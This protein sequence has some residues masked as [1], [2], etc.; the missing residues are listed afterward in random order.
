[1][2]TK[3]GLDFGF[4]DSK[5]NNSLEV[6]NSISEFDGGDYWIIDAGDDD[7]LFHT[8]K[9]FSEE[10][11]FVLIPKSSVLSFY[12]LP[13]KVKKIKSSNIKDMLGL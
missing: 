12:T 9:T 10:N 2:I 7:N 8:Y 11:S 4:Y 3:E 13:S 5:T 1:M 6:L